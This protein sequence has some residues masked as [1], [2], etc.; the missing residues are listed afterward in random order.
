MYY[1]VPIKDR[2]INVEVEEKGVPLVLKCTEGILLQAFINLVDNAVYWLTTSDR[3]DKTIKIIIDG[4]KSEVIFA[5]NGLGI[6]KD[7]YPYIF[8][9]F[10][11]TKGIKGRGL[12]LYIT[13]QLLDRYDF[14]IELIEKEKNKILSGANFLVSFGDAEAED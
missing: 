8:K 9:P 13:R 1:S 14:S 3:K 7:D 12:G 4:N 6:K 2:K 11:S 5:D 10:F